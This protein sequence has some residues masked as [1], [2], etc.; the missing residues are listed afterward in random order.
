MAIG[1]ATSELGFAPRQEGACAFLHVIGGEAGLE[2]GLDYE[3]Q[4]FALAF[5][6]DDMKEGT[7]AFL[8]R[9]KAEFTGR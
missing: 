4:C 7:S 6:T 2:A 1:L 8:A 9:R 3:S 5:S